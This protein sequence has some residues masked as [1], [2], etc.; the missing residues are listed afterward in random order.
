MIRPP[1]KDK[2]GTDCPNRAVGCHGTCEWHREFRQKVDKEQAYIQ[3]TRSNAVYAADNAYAHRK[4][5]RHLSHA[6]R[7]LMS[8]R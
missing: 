3:K 8:Q 4:D 6:Q 2:D 5:Y 7:K 1:C